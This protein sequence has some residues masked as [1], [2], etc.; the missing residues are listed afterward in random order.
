M[1][2]STR[3]WASVLGPAPMP[4]V[5]TRSALVMRAASGL[6]TPSSTTLNAPAS[7]RALASA[8]MPHHRNPDLGEP[9]RDLDHR[10]SPFQLDGVHAGLL[11]EAPGAGDGLL[12]GHL[13]GHERK[14][15]HEESLARAARNSFGVDQHVV[16]GHRQ[17]GGMAEHDHA[18]A[19]PDQQDWNS[20]LVE[21][22]RAQE[23]VGGEHGETPALVLE[24]LNV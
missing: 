15:A 9:P 24:S 11:D 19:V 6:G 1:S 4:M 21:D 3:T 13:V 20:R 18:E 14:I 17:G 23:V 10:P 8:R 5:G 16:Q 2:C 22:L 12:R 7:S